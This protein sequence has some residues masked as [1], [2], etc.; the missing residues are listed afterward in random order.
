MKDYTFSDSNG[1]RVTYRVD[2]I[3]N[4]NNFCVT[5]IRGL[6]P[7]AGNETKRYLAYRDIDIGK[8][9]DKKGFIEI[10]TTGN[11]GLSVRDSNGGNDTT[12]V[13]GA[14]TVI[15]AIAG[16]GQ[17]NFEEGTSLI[18]D[19]EAEY[20]HAFSNVVYFTKNG[21]LEPLDYT[22]NLSYQDPVQTGKYA[23]QFYL[24][25]QVAQAVNQT[26]F[27]CSYGQGDTSMVLDWNP[28]TPGT[29][30]TAMINKLVAFKAL[31]FAT[32]G[33][34]PTFLF[35]LWDQGEKDGR[36]LADANN[37]AARQLTLIDNIR[38]ALGEPNLK[39]ILPLLHQG[40]VSAS[41][42]PIQYMTTINAA[43]L[44]ASNSRSNVAVI[45]V[46]DAEQDAGGIHFSNAGYKAKAD[47]ELYVAQSLY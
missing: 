27:V 37:Y 15:Y 13:T 21:T 23:H 42:N 5:E 39:F 11:L 30:Y 22:N 14:P 32:Y 36:V 29:L 47:N 10:A 20:K 46:N 19:L 18:A 41:Q 16:G 24:Y 25:P 9:F 43:K 6:Y 45:N 12:I 31:I 44:A 35:Y 40:T 33:I 7:L 28:S 3:G 17:S 26:L 34:Y 2:A 1:V 4:G 38:T 8:Y